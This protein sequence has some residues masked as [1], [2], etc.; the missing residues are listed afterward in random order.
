MARYGLSKSRLIAWKQCPKRLWL[1]YH[2]PDLLE[3]TDETEHRF[4][5]GFEVGEVAQG[6]HSGG[7]LIE[8]NDDLSVALAS[9]L[10]AIDEYPNRPIFEATFQHDGVL[11]RA[12]LMLPTSGGYRMVEVKSSTSVKPYHV[13]DCAI[14]A[15]VLKQ[16]NIPLCSVELAHID[17]SFVYRGAGD[18]QGLLRY[19]Q[20]DDLIAPLMADVP[21]W[22]QGARNVLAGEEPNIEVGPQCDAPFECSFKTYCTRNIALNDTPEFSLDVFYRMH[23]PTKEL[24]RRKGF[25]DA[26]S[27][28]DEYLNETQRWIQRVSRSGIAEL[29][30]GAAMALTDLPYPRYYLDF[31]TINLAVPRWVDTSPYSTQVPFQ[32]S[33][34]IE[35]EMGELAHE[36]F[37]DVSGND[38]RRACAEQ[39][40]AILGNS[41]PIFVYYQAFEKA[42][43]TELAALFSDLAPK[44]R[45][46]NERIVDLLPIARANYYHPAMK[47]SWSIKAVLPTVAADLDY[48]SLAV[49]GGGDAQDA[50]RE[51]LHPQTTVDRRLNL[52]DGLYEYCKL[53]TL[54]MVRLAWFFQGVQ[55]Y[56]FTDKNVV[57]EEDMNEK[58]NKNTRRSLAL[59]VLRQHCQTTQTKAIIGPVS[60]IQRHMRLGYSAALDLVAELKAEG[61]LS[62]TSVVK[63]DK[64]R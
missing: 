16:N 48:T 28:P 33:C 43:I 12:D 59:N 15:W 62:V 8:D 25:V 58:D 26:C 21:E 51:I 47:G 39:M 4:Q 37:L 17:T 63:H 11:V 61:V 41:G 2:R 53:D 7:I 52:T 9:T 60:L 46:I 20:L 10:K 31:E 56:A 54:A 36:M 22:I 57:G 13:D 18:H 45:A 35:T 3:I 40:I 19:E 38:P 30:P 64:D 23:E 44:L 29:L 24:L 49:S 14:Q 42:R 32:W 55:V 50:Y 27:V 5:I 6:L 1:Q 34:H